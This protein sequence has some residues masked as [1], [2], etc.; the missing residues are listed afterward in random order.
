MKKIFLRTCVFTFLA[1]G[2]LVGCTS[3]NTTGVET[4]GTETEG[5]IESQPNMGGKTGNT[6]GLDSIATEEGDTTNENNMETQQ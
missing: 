2:M 4:E 6:A 3:E 5:N 1:A